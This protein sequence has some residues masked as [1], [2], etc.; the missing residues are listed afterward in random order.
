M[1]WVVE[2]DIRGCGSTMY[3]MVFVDGPFSH[4]AWA[5]A[6]ELADEVDEEV[7]QDPFAD[8]DYHTP[9]AIHNNSD[10]IS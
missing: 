2:F 8:I 1:F 4:S 9:S 5:T 3:P 10:N 6:L 7:S